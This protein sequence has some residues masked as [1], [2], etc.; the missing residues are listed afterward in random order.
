MLAAADRLKAQMGHHTTPAPSRPFAGR[1]AVVTGAA[2]GLGFAIATALAERGAIVVMNGTDEEALERA[3]ESLR[4][5]FGNAQVQRVVADVSL[6]LDVARLVA[7]AEREVG[8]IDVLVNNAAIQVATGLLEHTIED[9]D[10]VIAVNLRGVF[11]CT[12]AVLPGMIRAG[13]GSIVNL[14]SIAA[15][16]ATTPHI[17]YAASKAAVLA[18]TRDVACEVAPHGIRVNAIAPGPIETPMT[19]ALLTDDAKEA[20]RRAIPLGRWGTPNDV[21]AAVAYLASD[22][23]AFVTGA[24]LPVSGGAD[25]RLGY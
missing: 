8:H 7:E 1:V 2:R 15:L 20:I 11:L 5:V 21:A 13:R 25:L 19:A 14:A 23:A 16:H 6:P 17:S 3:S 4:T 18:L 24:T 22:E 9:W 10:R 12:R